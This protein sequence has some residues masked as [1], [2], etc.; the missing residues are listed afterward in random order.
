MSRGAAVIFIHMFT[1]RV[2]VLFFHV[3]FFVYAAVGAVLALL[4]RSQPDLPCSPPVFMLLLTAYD[5]CE[6]EVVK[7]QEFICNI[8]YL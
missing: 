4:D 8:L 1:G 3:A 2:S 5:T 7:L 6:K